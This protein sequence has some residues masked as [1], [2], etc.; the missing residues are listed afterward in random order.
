[1]VNLRQ[2]SSAI[3]CL[4]FFACQ[5]WAEARLEVTPHSGELDEQFLLSVIVDSGN[6]IGTPELGPTQDF[7]VSYIG[8]QTSVSII[9]GKVS[10]QASYTFRLI[11]RRVGTLKTPSATIEVDGKLI[12]L[13]GRDVA[14]SE[15][16]TPAPTRISGV[17]LRQS[18]SPKELFVGQQADTTL[19][20]RTAI[21]LIDPQFLDMAFDG[22]WTETIAENERNSQVIGGDQW[23]IL[24]FRK[25]LYPLISGELKIPARTLKARI[26]D[27]RRNRSLPFDNFDPFDFNILDNFFGGGS[28][29]DVSISSNE[30]KVTVKELPPPP[31]NL[32]RWGMQN[33]IV[34]ETTLELNVPPGDLSVGDS[35]SVELAVVSTGNLNPLKGAEIKVPDS[36]KL[37][38]EAPES[39]SF[40]SGGNLMQKKTFRLSLVALQPGEVVIPAIEL[41]YF[42]TS[43]EAY[44]AARTQPIRFRVSGE[45]TQSTIESQHAVPRVTDPSPPP[46]PST[47]EAR[48]WGETLADYISLTGLLFYTLSLAVILALARTVVVIRRN[49]QPGRELLAEI[50]QAKEVSAI[51]TTFRAYCTLVLSSRSPIVGTES[52]R[53]LAANRIED[54]AL[55]FEVQSVLDELDAASYDRTAICD[56]KTLRERCSAAARKLSK[57]KL[58]GLR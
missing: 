36:V 16:S 57:A 53:A 10:K 24:R 48:G 5:A 25:A 19:E 35:K 38:E 33:I 1:M 9:N 32:P 47:F 46:P 37:Y 40:E 23:D 30:L 18:V 12:T 58:R 7:G 52:L 11:P 55:S 20:L 50:D 44:R 51:G 3:L 42:D 49:Q 39:K 45:P 26:R 21:N 22:F 28:L 54:R 17:T 34:G 6:S 8:P 41:G 15:A 29:K 13:D 27:N 14:V 31:E 43:E 2:L 4:A 56:S